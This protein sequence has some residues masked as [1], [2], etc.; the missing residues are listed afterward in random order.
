ML[1]CKPHIAS[2]L[3]FAL[4]VVPGVARASARS[5]Q[6]SGIVPTTS[7]LTEV[8]A[9]AHLD[10]API[11]AQ[12]TERWTYVNGKHRIPVAVAVRGDDFRTSLVLGDATYTAGRSGGERWRGDGNGIVH[13]IQADLQGDALDRAPQAIFPLDRAGLTLAGET[14]TPLAAWVIA[15]DPAGDKPASLFIDRATGTI[16]RE[17]MRDGRRIVT[18]AFDTFQPFAGVPRARHWHIDDG[19]AANAIDVT[20]DAIEATSVAPEAV[21]FPQRRT[22]APVA[23]LTESV[24]LPARFSDDR[25]TLATEVDG[26]HEE[27]ILDTGTTSVTVDPSVVR[28]ST[29]EHAALGRISVG[30]LALE[31]ASVLSIPCFCSGILGLDFFYGHVLEI[32]YPGRKVR[33]LSGADARAVFADAKTTVLPINVDQGLPLAHASFGM[34]QGDFFALD[35][36][37]PRISVSLPFATRYASAIAAQWTRRGTPYV[38]TFLEGGIEVQPYRAGSLTFANTRTLDVPVD[39]QIPT[40]QTDDLRFPFDG[41]IGTDMLRNFDLYFDYDN[42]RLGL[43]S[44]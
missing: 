14:R 15:T 20:V 29:L 30:P 25:V 28:E 22:F 9:A 1:R 39:A 13:G 5:W 23:P 27:F 34:L 21:A 31:R 40:T 3:A 24:T 41:I 43:R 33:V 35:T 26:R 17:V 36:G 42:A 18:T 10:T 11:G 19:R 37:S 4:C 8:L 16:V 12:R 32:D 6:P 44:R 2:V 38:E 7:S